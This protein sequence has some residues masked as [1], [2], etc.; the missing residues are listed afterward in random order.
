MMLQVLFGEVRIRDRIEFVCQILL[1]YPNKWKL[2]H[3]IKYI[4]VVNLVKKTMFI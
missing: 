3:V 4:Y 2:K 1:K